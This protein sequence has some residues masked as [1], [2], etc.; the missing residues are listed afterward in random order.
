M[1]SS[2]RTRLLK[3]QFML[4]PNG[5]IETENESERERER[6][7]QH[8]IEQRDNTMLILLSSFSPSHCPGN[9]EYQFEY[10]YEYSLHSQHEYSNSRWHCLKIYYIPQHNVFSSFPFSVV[11]F[12]LFICSLSFIL[13]L[14]LPL[15]CFISMACSI[16]WRFFVV[17]SKLCA[18]SLAFR[19]IYK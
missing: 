16:I 19:M 17:Y 7:I 2:T 9:A 18:I 14:Y 8:G 15:F 11:R 12:Q 3:G 10:S 4:I 1:S 6:G 5:E 13:S